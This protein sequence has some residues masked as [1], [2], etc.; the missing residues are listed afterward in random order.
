[1]SNSLLFCPWKMSKNLKSGRSLS[2]TLIKLEIKF[3]FE[4]RMNSVKVNWNGALFLILT[5]HVKR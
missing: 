4:F 1:M 2:F 5:L 3:P